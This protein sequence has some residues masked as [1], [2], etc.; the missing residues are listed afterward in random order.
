MTTS[1]KPVAVRHDSDLTKDWPGHGVAP[2]APAGL[3]APRL[4]LGRSG[5]KGESLGGVERW[6]EPVAVELF[7]RPGRNLPGVG[8]F[9][10][11]TS[12]LKDLARVADRNPLNGMTVSWLSRAPSAQSSSGLSCVLRLCRS[13]FSWFPSGSTLSFPLCGPRPLA[14]AWS[15]GIAGPRTKS[16]RGPGSSEQDFRRRARN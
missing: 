13:S 11:C 3:D 7:R 10:E 4:G 16:R 9:T 1:L 14:S 6:R 2:A 12:R 8:R 5:Q 15:V